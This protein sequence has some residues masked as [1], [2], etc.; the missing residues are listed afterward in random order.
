MTRYL[1][2]SMFFFLSFFGIAQ[3]QVSNIEDLGASTL[4][5]QRG[6]ASFNGIEYLVERTEPKTKISKV[7]ADNITL[8]H[9]M[10]NRPTD[11]RY[12]TLKDTKLNN[13]G[14]IIKDDLIYE[15]YDYS[16]RVSNFV[17]GEEVNIIDL[18][19][20]NIQLRTSTLT[21]I[22]GL[23]VFKGRTLGMD[24]YYKYDE[25]THETTLIEWSMD[26][27]VLI[28]DRYLYAIDASS[29][30]ITGYDM[31]S[32][33]QNFEWTSVNGI[34]HFAIRQHNLTPHLVVISSS[35][36]IIRIK[37]NQVIN[38]IDCFAQSG[39]IILDVYF[40]ED[41]L[42]ILS[43]KDEVSRITV[44]DDESCNVLLEEELSNLG[45]NYFG[46]LF[47]DNKSL[48]N[49][50][51]IFSIQGSYFGNGNFAIIDLQT[52]NFEWI[53]LD[54]DLIIHYSTILKDNKWYCLAI[55]DIELYGFVNKCFEIDLETYKV[56]EVPISHDADLQKITIGENR[57][58]NQINFVTRSFDSTVEFWSFDM[59][60]REAKPRIEFEGAINRG[61]KNVDDL[62]SI[63]DQFYYTTLYALYATKGNT[64]EKLVTGICKMP[65]VQ[66]GNFVHTLSTIEDTLY[67][68]KINTTDQSVTLTKTSSYGWSDYR[69]F[70]TEDAVFNY[71]INLHHSRQGYYNLITES[72]DKLEFS[73][74]QGTS[75]IQVSSGNQALFRNSLS[76][77]YNTHFM[78][79]DFTLK[80]LLLFENKPIKFYSDNR[81]GFIAVESTNSS[82]T[83]RQTWRIDSS[84][85]VT[86]D[87]QVSSAG[88]FS[89]VDAT[90]SEMMTAIPL[91]AG[92]SINF[93]LLKDDQSKMISVP[94]KNTLYYRRHLYNIHGDKVV[95][96]TLGEDGYQATYFTYDD[97]PVMITSESSDDRL[98]STVIHADEIATF[99][100]ARNE[101]KIR[102]EVYD[103]AQEEISSIKYFDVIKGNN[104][105]FKLLGRIGGD[106]YLFAHHDGQNGNE[107]HLFDMSNGELSLLADVYPGFVGSYPEEFVKIED[108]IYFTA[109]AEDNSRQWFRLDA[110][111]LTKVIDISPVGLEVYPNPA[112]DYIQFKTSLTNYEIISS[113][114]KTILSSGNSNAN[115]IDISSLI[116]GLY[117][118]KGSDNGKR[119]VVG[120]FVVER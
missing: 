50:Y 104:W 81:G 113:T 9:E 10:T 48:P 84:G 53:D 31:V 102:I 60:T 52:N 56:T 29:H 88:I 11:Q 58:D 106:N 6:F 93:Y 12:Y 16:I 28:C 112:S 36:N 51:V 22:E 19:E 46:Q 115:R 42:C 3:V 101:H 89:N 75:T 77:I 45:T 91:P 78:R 23:I 97:A 105:N 62:I 24:A 30:T 71:A 4:F 18:C 13:S 14:L 15:A 117:W 65:I 54:T 100:H 44:L 86:Q 98:V 43:T 111:G 8:L 94:N 25:E 107:L 79:S 41:K 47:Q 17:T 64:T 74:G 114:G 49:R 70:A 120:S 69:D 76:G 82:L 119:Q 7:E 21:F 34:E 99:Y 118:I 116:P 96:E 67:Q 32:D 95:I 68:V 110:V 103:I 55:D 66:K 83:S 20:Q 33:L 39:S 35:Q 1:L 109:I 57:T 108:M 72:Y 38:E 63:G 26:K 5:E 90:S 85:E 2:L 92:D 59:E 87:I 73:E 37:D 61:V 80:K 40:R 27:D